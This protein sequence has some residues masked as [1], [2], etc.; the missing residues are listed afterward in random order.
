MLT[1]SAPTLKVVTFVPVR[2]AM[3]VT[4]LSVSTLTSV[5]PKLTIAM[6]MPL[7]KTHQ[8]VSAALAMLV[9]RA[10][11][12]LVTISMSATLLIHV[13]T[14]LFAPIARDF[15]SKPKI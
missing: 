14:T 12:L 11:E 1:L 4:A 6:T 10:M 15:Q 13:V 8:A 3:L 7:A 5:R 9:S 2:V